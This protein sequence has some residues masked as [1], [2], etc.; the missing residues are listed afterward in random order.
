MSAHYDMRATRANEKL[1][2]AEDRTDAWP[3]EVEP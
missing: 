2:G 3:S 1:K